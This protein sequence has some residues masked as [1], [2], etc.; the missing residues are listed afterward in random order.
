[1]QKSRFL[2]RRNKKMS[3]GSISDHKQVTIISFE[4]RKYIFVITI[5]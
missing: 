2:F 3:S 4:N 5:R 1:M